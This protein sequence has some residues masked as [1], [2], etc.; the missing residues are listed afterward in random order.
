MYYTSKVKIA[1]DTPKGVK[2]KSETYLVNAVS[3]T[4]AEQ[5]VHEDFKDSGIEFEV[6]SVSASQICKV[7]GSTKKL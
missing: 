2:W 7:I 6:K 1:I 5:L 3:V 4:H